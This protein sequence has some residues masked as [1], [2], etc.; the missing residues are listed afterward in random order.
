MTLDVMPDFSQRKQAQY[1]F[2][3]VG[4]AESWVNNGVSIIK[5][6]RVNNGDA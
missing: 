5:K 6:K 2:F 1:T 3:G 4:F